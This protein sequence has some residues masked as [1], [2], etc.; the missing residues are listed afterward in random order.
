VGSLFDDG[1][2]GVVYVHTHDLVE[3][4]FCFYSQ[5]LMICDEEV[6]GF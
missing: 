4:Y 5:T 6:Q 3:L 1:Y 2:R